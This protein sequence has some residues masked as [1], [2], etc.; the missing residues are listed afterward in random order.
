MSSHPRP[1]PSIGIH[2]VYS[3]LDWYAVELLALLAVR[4]MNR[5]AREM[6]L[7]MVLPLLVLVLPIWSPQV[8]M[9]FNLMG[10]IPL[11]LALGLLI[12]RVRDV[13]DRI[14]ITIAVI[15]LVCVLGVL[16]SNFVVP[17]ITPQEYAELRIV[18]EKVDG[19]YKGHAR[20][21]IRS[22]HLRY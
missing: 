5:I 16:T 7:L 13:I 11:S 10:G 12:S 6:A 19:V 4:S 18:I 9:R 2:T 14:F 21:V 15:G 1:S 20:I 22:P 3:I 17:S 8:A